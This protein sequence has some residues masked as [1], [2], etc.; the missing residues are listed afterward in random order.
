[1][2]SEPRFT[3]TQLAEEFAIT[4]RAIRFYEDKGLLTPGR[5]GQTRVYG[6]RDRARLTLVVRGRRVGFTLAEIKELVD[7]YD[8]PDGGEKQTRHSLVKFRQ[9]IDSLLRQRADIDEA[10]RELEA[11]CQM[12]ETSLAEREAMSTAAARLKA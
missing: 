3:I 9:R 1:M 11:G 5:N 7:L 10:I 8:L 12:L 2:P 6:P 4:P